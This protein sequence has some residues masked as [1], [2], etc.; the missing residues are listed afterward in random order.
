[1]K[2]K[3]TVSPKQQSIYNEKER[4]A[5]EHFAGQCFICQ[6]K[7]GSGFAFHHLEYDPERK[8]HK[9]FKSSLEYNVYMFPEILEFPYRFYLLCRI[10]HA[11]I[12]QPRYGFL[13]HISKD[14]L[15]RL[16]IVARDTIPGPRKKK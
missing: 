15:E 8:T 4:I 1:L 11:R 10:C 9:D 2:V 13:G 16:Y 3:R 6:L 14:R 5:H 12:D 7:Y